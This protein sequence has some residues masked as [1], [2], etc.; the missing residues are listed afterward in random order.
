MDNNLAS[1]DGGPVA[2]GLS[3]VLMW[4]GAAAMVA[5]MLHICADVVTRAL[6]HVSIVGTLEFVTY[7]YMVSVVFLPLALTQ[8]ERGHVIV[9]VF[10]Q[11]ASP[12]T[13]VW[14]DRGTQIFTAVY[15]AFIGWWGF[16]EAIR[17]TL[18]N[19]VITIIATDVPLWPSRWLLPIGLGAMLVVIL[20]QLYGSFRNPGQ[21]PAA[22]P[23]GH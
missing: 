2:R 10:S 19:E 13:L 4:L 3:N 18:R 11:H 6:F 5:M 7:L 14:I 12:R 22:G 9:E 8:S 1:G 15:V 17:S 23:S 21:L 20:M 16:K